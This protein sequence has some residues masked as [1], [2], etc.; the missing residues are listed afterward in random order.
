MIGGRFIGQT[1]TR[2]LDNQKIPTLALGS[3]DFDLSEG[4]AS[5]KL[6]HIHKARRHSDFPV[7]IN[8]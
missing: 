1:L 2:L 3:R 4:D 6:A 8:T 5:D 7:C